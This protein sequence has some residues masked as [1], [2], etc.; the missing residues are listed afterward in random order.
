[1]SVGCFCDTSEGEG[2]ARGAREED[3]RGIGHRAATTRRTDPAPVT[4]A[5][6]PLIFIVVVSEKDGARRGRVTVMMHVLPTRH[7]PGLFISSRFPRRR[8]TRHV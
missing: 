2:S 7:L 6:L 8:M 4:M 3:P 5:V 1:M